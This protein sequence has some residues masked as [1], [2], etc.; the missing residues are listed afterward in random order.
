MGV[1]TEMAV[2]HAAD[3][4][5]FTEADSFQLALD[6]Q[7]ADHAMFE[8]L[9]ELDFGEIYQEMGIMLVTEADEAEGKKFSINAMKQKVISAIDMI[10]GLIRKAVEA[11]S[12]KWNQLMDKDAPLYTKYKE[13]FHKNIGDC[14]LTGYKV[15]DFAKFE[16][17]QKESNE[18]IELRNIMSITDIA[19]M[20]SVDAINKKKEEILSSIKSATENAK[21]CDLNQCFVD[22]SADKQLKDVVNASKIDE[23]MKTGCRN[24]VKQ[25]RE[26][27]KKQISYLE[28]TKKMQS[29]ASKNDADTE[30]SKLSA[31]NSIATAINHLITTSRNMQIAQIRAIYGAT[32][33][34]WIAVA[35]GKQAKA[36]DEKS[37]EET[38]QTVNASYVEDLATLSDLYM[39]EAFV[40]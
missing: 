30:K 8:A 22:G 2:K 21:K 15:P 39:E 13:A 5:P 29:S 20:D 37:G 31:I 28:K 26:K 11:F 14:T 38:T 35:S 9:I 3:T 16:A 23:Y 34:I 25:L 1:Y 27:A 33:K 6:M 19:G 32:R 40:F 4:T 36:K 18:D 17:A 12:K 10:I 24:T 7:R